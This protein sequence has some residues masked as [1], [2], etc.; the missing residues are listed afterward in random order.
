MDE[1]VVTSGAGMG[2]MEPNVG[3]TIE[4]ESSRACHGCRE[5]MYVRVTERVARSSAEALTALS[6][7][8]R[9]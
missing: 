2:L 8:W 4:V 9:R 5:S 7:S 6:D 3:A 1:T